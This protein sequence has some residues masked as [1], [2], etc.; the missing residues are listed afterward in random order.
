[1]LAP[2]KVIPAPLPRIGLEAVSEPRVRLRKIRKDDDAYAPTGIDFGGFL[3]FPAVR[4]G[5]VYT[6]NVAQAHSGKQNDIGLR[7]RP[8]LRTESQWVCFFLGE[9]AIGDFSFYKDQPD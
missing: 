3:A 4:I 5:A 8:S 9:D 2:E 6:D 7:I 1:A